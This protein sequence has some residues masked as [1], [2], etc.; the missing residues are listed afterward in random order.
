MKKL[1]LLIAAA[2]ALL[3]L[4]ALFDQMQAPKKRINATTQATGAMAPDFTFTDREGKTHRLSTLKGKYVLLNFWATWCAPC[5]EEFPV[6][7]A[8]AEEHRDNLVL[9]AL[10]VDAPETDIAAFVKQFDA[11]TQK[12]LA[13]A[14]VILARD[15]EQE[16]AKQFQ[17]YKFPETYLIAPDGT[18]RQKVA[19][20]LTP[21]TLTLP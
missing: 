18:I 13:G 3:A 4:G 2:L 11:T 21:D 9:L 19:G 12:Q 14:N 17:V 1:G 15:A 7:A 6:L 16:V 20:V 10:S 5:K 8:F